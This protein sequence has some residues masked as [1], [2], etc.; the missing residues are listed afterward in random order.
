MCR[1]RNS[2][3]VCPGSKV[4]FAIAETSF[5]TDLTLHCFSSPWHKYSREVLAACIE[6]NQPQDCHDDGQRHTRWVQEHMIQKNVH[7][8][9]S[10]QQQTEWHEPIHQQQ[11]TARDL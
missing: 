2:A 9:R 5:E 6:D 11:R 1:A 8:Y 4:H 3:A 7:N 10:Q